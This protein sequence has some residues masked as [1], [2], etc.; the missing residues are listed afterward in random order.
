MCYLNTN[1]DHDGLDP[2]SKTQAPVFL[3]QPI[4]R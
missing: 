1:L 3:I 2:L 4:F